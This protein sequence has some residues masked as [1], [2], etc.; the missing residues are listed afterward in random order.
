MTHDPIV[1]EQLYDAPTSAVWD[2][3]TQKEQMKNWY[4][5]LEDFQA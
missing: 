3:I 1:V 5:D 2:A 4:F